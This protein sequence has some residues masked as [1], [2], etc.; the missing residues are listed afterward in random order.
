[1]WRLLVPITMLKIG[2]CKADFVLTCTVGY[3]REVVCP[4]VTTSKH[5]IQ[6]VVKYFM[7]CD[8]ASLYNLVNKANLV[9]NFS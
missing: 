7:F 3:E 1:M 6:N 8:R 2:H 4:Y 9:R 5:F